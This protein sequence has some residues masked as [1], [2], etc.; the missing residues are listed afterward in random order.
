MMK[1]AQ[2]AKAASTTDA[3]L[4]VD[5]CSKVRSIRQISVSQGSDAFA[6]KTL[7]AAGVGSA[8]LFTTSISCVCGRLGMV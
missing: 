7:L 8:A 1:G 2:G 6:S 4:A 3:A 5:D